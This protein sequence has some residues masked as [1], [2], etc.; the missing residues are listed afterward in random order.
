MRI[1]LLDIAFYTGYSLVDY[2]LNTKVSKI[3]ETGIINVKSKKSHKCYFLCE[4]IKKLINV[5]NPNLVITEG[6]FYKDLYMVDGAVSAAIP[7]DISHVRLFSK[8]ARFLA[9]NDGSL[10]KDTANKLIV[11]IY[12]ELEGKIADILDAMVLFQ[13]WKVAIETNQ[14]LKAPK[15]VPKKPRVPKVK[16]EKIKKIKAEPKKKKEKPKN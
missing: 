4:E 14:P 7:P 2:D 10:D 6:Q 12:P 5:T 13:A 8:R 3:L 9:F 11:E 15:K 16:V 1:L